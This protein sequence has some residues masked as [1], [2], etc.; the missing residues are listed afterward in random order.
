MRRARPALG[1]IVELGADA[2]IN[3]RAFDAAYFAIAEVERALS[4]FHS[5]SD[6]HRF[7]AAPAGA[8]RRIT[9]ETACVLRVAAELQCESAGRFDITQGTGPH[10]WSI[11]ED[12]RLFKHSDG[13][14]ID[15]GGIGKGFAVDRAFE[16]LSRALEGAACWVNAGGDLRVQGMEVPVQLRDEVRGGVRPW[17]V[18]RE[19][20]LA[21]SYFG[22]SARSLLAGAA[23]A[24]HVSVAASTCLISDALT[25]I[26]ALSA[27]DDPLLARFGATAWQ[28]A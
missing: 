21:T 5:E 16:A 18:L 7:N 26:V 13:V 20:A 2:P 4:I 11:N 3:A 22:A 19:G 1:T 10:D 27:V 25:K 6:I 14:R 8:A 15:L 9:D 23:R 28:H 12:G 17:M 24:R